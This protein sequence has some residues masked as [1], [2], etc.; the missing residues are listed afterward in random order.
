MSCHEIAL[1]RILGVTTAQRSRFCNAQ[2][3]LAE[4]Y[5]THK[6]VHGFVGAY[7]V[8]GGPG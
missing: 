4:K 8:T 7:S 6:D 3:K 1:K 5:P 2:L